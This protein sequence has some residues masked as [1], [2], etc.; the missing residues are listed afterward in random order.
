ML[1]YDISPVPGLEPAV[2]QE[3]L[4]ELAAWGRQMADEDAMQALPLRVRFGRVCQLFEAGRSCVFPDADKAREMKGTLYE[5]VHASINALL[6]GAADYDVPT[7]VSAWHALR[8]VNPKAGRPMYQ[9]DYDRFFG[10]FKTVSDGTP[11]DS[12]EE[13]QL[14]EVRDGYMQLLS[15]NLGS[16]SDE[17]YRSESYYWLTAKAIHGYSPAFL[18]EAL[19]RDAERRVLSLIHI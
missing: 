5:V 1:P 12:E 9:R 3:C 19:A 17:E 13:R 8:L 14:F 11:E 10:F 2:S 6:S 7:V 4:R 16:R 18:S 15:D